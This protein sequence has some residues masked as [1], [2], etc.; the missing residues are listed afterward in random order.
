MCGSEIVSVVWVVPGSAEQRRYAIKDV[1]GRA[2]EAAT[3]GIDDFAG[4]DEEPATLI[5]LLRGAEQED[6]VTKWTL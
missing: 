2:G 6:V 1:S 4:L 3:E 5:G